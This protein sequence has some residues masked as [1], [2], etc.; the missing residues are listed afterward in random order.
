[1]NYK[2]R[3]TVR[4][5]HDA[6]GCKGE[7]IVGIH[8]DADSPFD[9]ACQ[10]F[11]SLMDSSKETTLALLVTGE[12]ISPKIFFVKNIVKQVPVRTREVVQPA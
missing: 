5:L 10:R 3:Y 4:T 1:M 8:I 11:K 12:G 6:E 2:T 7:F 9:A